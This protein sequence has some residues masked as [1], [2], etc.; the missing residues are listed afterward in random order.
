MV[1]KL[2]SPLL[3]ERKNMEYIMKMILENEDRCSSREEFIHH[4]APVKGSQM[5]DLLKHDAAVSKITTAYR[6]K[7]FY[8]L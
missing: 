1:E 4:G 8:F 7:T 3:R 5:I 6:W 2:K